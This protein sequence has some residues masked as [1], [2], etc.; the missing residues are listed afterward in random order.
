MSLARLRAWHIKSGGAKPPDAKRTHWGGPAMVVEAVSGGGSAAK[1]IALPGAKPPNL[2]DRSVSL[3]GRKFLNFL[4]GSGIGSAIY[5]SIAPMQKLPTAS[6]PSDM[7]DRWKD[8]K[9]WSWAGN[10]QIANDMRYDPQVLSV[11][12]TSPGSV[13][14]QYTQDIEPDRFVPALAI[15][16]TPVRGPAAQDQPP[17]PPPPLPV[18]GEGL[19]LGLP[20][21]HGGFMRPSVAPEFPASGQLVGANPL[22]W[23]DTSS[24]AAPGSI[25]TTPVQVGISIGQTAIGPTVKVTTTP[26]SAAAVDSRPMGGDEKGGTF[27]A[28]MVIQQ[29]VTK[30]LGRASE[31]MDMVDVLVNNT[32]AQT[33]SGL[34]VNAMAVERGDS[35][36]VLT[37]ILRGT[38]EV[39]I[40]GFASGMILDKAGD[41]LIARF[42]RLGM[43]GLVEAGY[44]LP[45]GVN[46][47]TTGLKRIQE[48]EK[49]GL[50]NATLSR[51]RTRN[52]TELP[53][54]VHP[55]KPTQAYLR[56]LFK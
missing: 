22:D 26:V 44:N 12:R 6:H 25:P 20:S 29:T 23:L 19:N 4:A 41:Q 46:A 1:A 14:L 45:V 31:V 15:P 40:R 35:A 33:K 21:F 54:W 53:E 18:P 8:P 10:P 38:Y 36:A 27:R 17:A 52:L 50:S 30:T 55:D 37:G 43:K 24:I 11:E 16:L 47:L 28:W 51:A 34:V 56:S 39:D 32:Y 9:L 49:G 2:Q 5:F 42:N 13:V 48:I 7:G 3:L